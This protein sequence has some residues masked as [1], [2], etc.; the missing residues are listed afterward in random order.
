MGLGFREHLIN[1]CG[2]LSGEEPAGRGTN[3]QVAALPLRQAGSP[4]A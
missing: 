4:V 2:S 3:V 1:P